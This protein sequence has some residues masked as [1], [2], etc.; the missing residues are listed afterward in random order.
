[1]KVHA[2]CKVLSWLILL[3]IQRRLLSFQHICSATEAFLWMAGNGNN[4]LCVAYQV[5]PR[6]RGT[7]GVCINSQAVP[8]G[9]ARTYLQWPR[10]V[11]LEPNATTD[12]RTGKQ[13]WNSECPEFSQSCLFWVQVRNLGGG[14]AHCCS[15]MGWDRGTHERRLAEDPAASPT[16]PASNLATVSFKQ[17]EKKAVLQRL[18]QWQ[19]TTKSKHW[20]LGLQ[21]LLCTICSRHK[22]SNWL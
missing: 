2:V 6:G 16:P 14:P 21:I 22:T 8:R 4:Y 1:M 15:D 18:G 12:C 17:K 13:D 20:I 9:T 3:V 11:D 7:A 19:Q 5:S 10:N